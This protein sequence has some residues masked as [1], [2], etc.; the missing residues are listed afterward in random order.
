MELSNNAPP[1]SGVSEL[2]TCGDGEIEAQFGDVISEIRNS[3]ATLPLGRSVVRKFP[4]LTFDKWNSRRAKVSRLHS[5]SKLGN[6]AI[7][8]DNIA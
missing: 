2:S 3:G 5:L 1:S 7:S 8:L 6:S 4:T